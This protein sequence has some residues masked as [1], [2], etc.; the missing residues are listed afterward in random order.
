MSLVRAPH[1]ARP[2]RGGGPQTPWRAA[3]GMDAQCLHVGGQAGEAD[4]QV[5]VHLEDFGHVA[6]VCLVLHPEPQVAGDG[7]TPVAG[8][9]DD[10]GA[11]VAHDT[12]GGWTA[13]GAGPQGEVLLARRRA[14]PTSLSSAGAVTD[15]SGLPHRRTRR[16]ARREPR[17]GGRHRRQK[18]VPPWETPSPPQEACSASLASSPSPRRR[19]G[20]LASVVVVDGR[21]ADGPAPS[22]A[23]ALLKT[24]PVGVYTSARTWR[25]SAVT[26]WR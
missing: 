9:G 20:A 12:H 11:V 4:E 17:T 14:T 24:L 5:V 25:R 16:A 21:L 7:H 6:G 23:A 15:H 18:L 8:H 2:G 1:C 22:T 13:G 10:A 19:R 26:F 3:G